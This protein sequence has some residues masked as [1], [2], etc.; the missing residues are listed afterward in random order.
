MLQLSAA[1]KRFGPR[2]LFENADW[3]ITPN[4]RTALVGA[5]G[6]GKSTLLKVL[7]GTE[8]L[9]Y[10]SLQRTRGMTIGYLPQEGLALCGRSVFAECL[11]VFAELRSMEQELE[12]LSTR[13]AEFDPATPEY[14]AAADRFSFLDSHFRLQTGFAGKYLWYPTSREKR[15]RCGAPGV[16]SQGRELM[17][18]AQLL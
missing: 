6:T 12:T 11:S 13:L 3:L 7:A 5:N 18:L 4:E 10:G 15:A 17:A 14:A 2:V 1:G 16:R 8:S 9:D